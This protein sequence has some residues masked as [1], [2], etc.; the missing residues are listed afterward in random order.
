M[1]RGWGNGRGKHGSNMVRGDHCV[2]VLYDVTVVCMF[3]AYTLVG[4]LENH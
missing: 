3:L 2:K 1:A 4:E